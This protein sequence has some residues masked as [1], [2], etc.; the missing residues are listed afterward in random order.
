[1][2]PGC[3]QKTFRTRFDVQIMM[4]DEYQADGAKSP[5]IKRKHNLLRYKKLY[6][7]GPEKHP[8]VPRVLGLWTY[9]DGYLI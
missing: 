7:L 1:M 3:A 8:W 6:Q 9:T 4:A 2:N 5:G